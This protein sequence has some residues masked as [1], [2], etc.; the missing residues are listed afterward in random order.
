MTLSQ[1]SCE[2]SNDSFPL[3]VLRSLQF[4]PYVCFAIMTNKALGNF[5][6]ESYEKTFT[7]TAFL[8]FNCTWCYQDAV[9]R[10]YCS[11]YLMVQPKGQKPGIF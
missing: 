6:E 4:L 9:I 3:L 2:S 11:N 1:I 7:E 5:L 10:R 8:K